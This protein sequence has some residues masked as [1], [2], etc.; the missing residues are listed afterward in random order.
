M[1]TQR[2]MIVPRSSKAA[3]LDL[4]ERPHLHDVEQGCSAAAEKRGDWSEPIVR[5]AGAARGR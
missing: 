4:D 3:N 5:S 2:F 1:L